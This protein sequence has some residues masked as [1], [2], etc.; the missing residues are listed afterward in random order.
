MTTPAD[1]IGEPVSWL[2]LE[3]YR[4]RE[5]PAAVATEVEAHLAACPVCAACATETNQPLTFSAPV[6]APAT[7]RGGDRVG[8]WFRTRAARAVA[9][10]AFAG[11]AA[12]VVLVARSIERPVPG[13]VALGVR[14]TLPGIKG[15]AAA[16]ELVRERQG[17]VVQGADTFGV[18]DRWKVLV[19]CPGERVLFWDVVVRDGAR[20][21]FPL[22]PTAPLACGNHVPLPG[23]FRISGGDD[24]RV[25]VVLS[26]DPVERGRLTAATPGED[27]CVTVHPEK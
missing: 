8:A 24:T 25:C 19:T 6:I 21:D 22:S 15:G 10:L 27:V 4:L 2:R 1:C 16:I 3:R 26:S 23:A 5:L 18:D 7:S 14:D 13:S 20:A 12:A 17:V 11:V 9:G